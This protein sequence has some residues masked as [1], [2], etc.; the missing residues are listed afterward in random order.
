MRYL[1]S[2]MLRRREIR[3]HRRPDIAPSPSPKEYPATQAIALPRDWTLKEAR[4]TPLLQKRRSRRTFGDEP[5]SLSDLAY[6]LW[7]TQGVTA[8]AGR[9]LLRTSPSAGALY[10]IETY[11]AVHNVEGLADGLY[12]FKVAEFS[13]E[14]LQ[15]GDHGEDVALACLNQQF[16]AGAGVVFLWTAVFRRNA[17]K[18]GERGLRYVFMDAAHICQNLLLA[19]EATGNCGCPVAAFFDEELNSLLGVDGAEESVV[20]LAGVGTPHGTSRSA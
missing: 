5:I 11:I 7:A 20:Y 9:H 10:P 4:L 18:Y 17:S 6:M 13:L 16:L 1:S 8:Q 3:A 19:V 12:H 2:T 14:L 15:P